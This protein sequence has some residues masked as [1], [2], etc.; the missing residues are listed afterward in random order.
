MFKNLAIYYDKSKKMWTNVGDGKTKI[1][2]FIHFEGKIFPRKKK[3]RKENR[4]E[5]KVQKS[6]GS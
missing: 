2:L 4:K 3:K 1:G 5:K 6:C